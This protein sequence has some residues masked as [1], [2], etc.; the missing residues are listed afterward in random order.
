MGVGAYLGVKISAEQYQGMLGRYRDAL[1][2]VGSTADLKT[3]LEVLL[4]RDALEKAA[5]DYSPTA[6]DL[7]LL[8]ELDEN[9][10]RH[11]ETIAAHGKELEAWCDRTWWWP[12]P[13]PPPPR[14]WLS[15]QDWLWSAGSLIFLS[16]SASLVLN[17]AAR[18]WGGGIATAGT[19]PIVTQT[20]L[21]LIAGQGA[22]TE[23]GR[24]AWR[25]FLKK[26]GIDEAYY[27]EWSCAGALAVFGLT[28]AVHSSLP[29]LATVYNTK[30]YDYYAKGQLASALDNYQTA[31][32]LRPDYPTAHFHSGL[33]YEDLQQY[34]QAR[35]QYQTV[36]Q[37]DPEAVPLEVWLSA[38]NN[39]A[40]LYLLADNARVAAPL[41]I[42]AQQAVDAERSETEADIAEVNYSLLKNLGWVRLKQERYGEARTSLEEAIRFD[43]EVLQ[44]LAGA[45]RDRAAAY[46]L[47][48]QVEDGEGNVDAAD[49]LWQD[50]LDRANL[51]DPDE[52]AWVGIYERRQEVSGGDSE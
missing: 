51:G 31:L 24:Q 8:Q 14:P 2:S 4:A 19:L 47:L 13:P 34:D 26:R 7:L 22:L 9:L 27:Q 21:T 37:S 46:C 36:V 6:A 45:S 50:C 17:T 35:D 20:V 3:V 28:A 11:E 30:G 29:W 38:H 48:A 16:A 18:F 25:S 44:N 39:L 32:S 43:D 33:V 49:A 52:D 41:L 42:G 12:D 15:R 10:K 1:D 5:A 40:R 23:S